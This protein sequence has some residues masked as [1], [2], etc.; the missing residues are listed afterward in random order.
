MQNLRPQ[1]LRQLKSS[2]MSFIASRTEQPAHTVSRDEVKAWILGNGLAPKTQRT[3]LTDLRT[4]YNW[5]KA[6]RYVAD[7]PCDGIAVA[8]ADDEEVTVFTPE[9]CDRLLTAAWNHKDRVWNASGQR[10]EPDGRPFLRVM[11]YAALAMFIGVRPH[12]V[13][14]SKR[15][16]IDWEGGTFL[17]KGKHAKGRSRRVVELPEN[18]L[19]W[20]RLWDAECPGGWIIPPNFERLWEGLRRTAKLMPWPHDVLRHTSASMHLALY[21]Q[22]HRT[23][24][25][26]GHSADEDTL[27]RHYRAVRMPDGKPIT[28]A[29]AARFYEIRPKS[30]L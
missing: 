8:K 23:K 25:M 29:V 4:L 26:L 5:A 21:E 17:V 18:A 10:W 11:G 14:R 12:E 2:C 19:Q 22:E 3:Y 9:Q 20:L 27:F 24:A 13:R 30:L 7:N 16:E 28:K 6:E 1:S 15:S